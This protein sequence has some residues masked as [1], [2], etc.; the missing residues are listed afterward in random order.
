MELEMKTFRIFTTMLITLTLAT[1]SVAQDQETQ[2][3]QENI[4]QTAS[5]NG[6]TQWV[7]LLETAGMTRQFEEDEQFTVFVPTNQAF[8]KLPQALQDQLESDRSAKK[9]V[10]YLV[11]TGN[12][13]ASE[14]SQQS[15]YKTYK[16]LDDQQG[17]FVI[18]TPQ[19]NWE[20][21]IS[22]Q[23]IVLSSP[24]NPTQKAKVIKSIQCKNG[25]IHVLD[26][27]L[28]PSSK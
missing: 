19:T 7:Q 13:P 22:D 6:L 17:T 9:Q 27:M 15:S 28:T 26:T 23:T 3:D 21:Q 18:S 24:L 5:Q 12:V 14:V 20:I 8:D 25:I 16:S 11:L 1:V 4:V 2:K 10:N